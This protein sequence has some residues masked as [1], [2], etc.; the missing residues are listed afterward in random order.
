MKSHVT[1]K[2]RIKIRR[3]DIDKLFGHYLLYIIIKI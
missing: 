3:V 1:T 2:I